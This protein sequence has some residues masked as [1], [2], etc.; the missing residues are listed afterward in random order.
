MSGCL[1]IWISVGLDAWLSVYLEAW[2]FVGNLYV[3]LLGYL[4]VAVDIG[5]RDVDLD[6]ERGLRI[7]LLR[8]GTV[9]I[10]I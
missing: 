10:R 2:V 5:V 1:N 7:N 8:P 6:E 4:D 3:W 9:S